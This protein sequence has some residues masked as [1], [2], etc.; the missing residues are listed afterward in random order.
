[1]SVT[2]HTTLGEL[3]IEIFCE[4]VP[5]AAENFLALCASKYYD[6]CIFHRNI[7][8]FMAQAGDPT[9]SGKGG[10]SIW[11]KPFADEIRSTLKFNAR[12]MVA[13]ANSGPDTNKS[14]FFIT[15]AKQPH[16]DGKYTIFGKVIDGA[17]STLDIME[18][19]P[20]N[21]KNRP[22]SEIKLTHI[23]IH[24]NPI[25]DAQLVSR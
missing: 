17:D 21:P 14:Q 25:A 8:G 7:K 5:K 15:Y 20:V 10:Q 13:M 22:L 11:G 23:T 6:D 1:M 16:L 24:A 4:A 18:R 12:G 9:G 19:A 2:L 3:K